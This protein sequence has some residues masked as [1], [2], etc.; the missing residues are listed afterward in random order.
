MSTSPSGAAPSLHTLL[1]R[2]QHLFPAKPFRFSPFWIPSLSLSSAPQRTKTLR[3]APT[4][5]SSTSPALAMPL[6]SRNVFLR[7]HR[8]TAP[9]PPS[10]LSKRRV[11]TMATVHQAR[12]SLKT[13]GGNEQNEHANTIVFRGFAGSRWFPGLYSSQANTIFV[14]RS[15]VHGSLSRRS[16]N[17]A[18]V[19]SDVLHR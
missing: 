19:T 13:H 12:S 8:N 2:R 14:G 4:P 16:M 3:G 1:H 17:N 15:M 5:K 6:L 18:R 10:T 9:Q 7:M 11:L